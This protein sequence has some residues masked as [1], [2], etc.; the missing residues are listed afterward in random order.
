MAQKDKTLGVFQSVILKLYCV[1]KLPEDFVKMQILI[2]CVWGE[3]W[4]SLFLISSQVV[5][6]VL[7]WDCTV[8]I[9]AWENLG[10]SDPS[11]LLP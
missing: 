10:L 9:I 11:V 3:A 5:L 2:L 7:V 1:Y 6:L 4:D 8:I